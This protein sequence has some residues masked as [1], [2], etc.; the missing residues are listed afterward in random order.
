MSSERALLKSSSVI[1]Q[2]CGNIVRREGDGRNGSPQRTR[3]PPATHDD[4][5]GGATTL[6]TTKLRP[7]SGGRW[8]LIGSANRRP[9][10][11]E[12][13]VPAEEGVQP[14]ISRC[15]PWARRRAGPGSDPKSRV[16]HEVVVQKPDR[17][18]AVETVGRLF[19]TDGDSARSVRIEL[20][21]RLRL[22]VAELE[23]AFF[24]YVRSE[25]PDAA[26]DRDAQLE[27]GLRE[28]I[29]ACIDCG[30]ESI[31]RGA[32]WS[33]PMPAAVIAHARRGA[34][35]GMS[36]TT[37]LRR[38]VAVHMLAWS[39]VLDEVAHRELPDEQRPGLLLQTSAAMGSVLAGVQA[40]I[41]EA[42][43][44]EIARRARSHEQR[45]DEIVR[46]L[47]AAEPVDSGEL[48]ELGYELDAWHL[49]VI[50]TGA[51]AK[52]AV[53]RLERRLDCELL[54]VACGGQTVW[55]WLGAPRR[56]AFA[57]VER[58]LSAQDYADVSLALSE[59]A[60]GVKGWRLTHQEA[61]GAALVARYEPRRITRYADVA[62]EATALQDEA[63]ADSLIE[64]Y[65]FPLDGMGIGGRAARRTLRALFDAEHNVSSAAHALNVNRSTVHRRRDEIEGRLGCALHEHQVDIEI[66]M[67]IEE[68]RQQRHA[69]FSERHAVGEQWRAGD[70]G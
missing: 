61:E 14:E 9:V 8:Q 2:D 7:T 54:S 53:R 69:T 17:A 66:A 4:A 30:L 26:T 12:R 25:V 23:G 37:A 32:S 62:A 63:L 59:P 36:L 16:A 3:Q 28:M 34:S 49:A 33:G 10:A 64:R 6:T 20:V 70:T 52:K 27:G 24:A 22:R 5:R 29:A 1:M 45:R 38:C 47:L 39:I 50:A 48:A 19:V 60:R 51:D 11:P 41:A 55:A 42:H 56:L 21:R 44:L 46:K 13:V 43:S 15:P 65:L 58:A 40:E 31:E 67:R 57:D 18:S 68:L 35:Q